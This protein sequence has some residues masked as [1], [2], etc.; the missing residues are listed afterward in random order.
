MASY[1]LKYKF[2]WGGL[3][4]WHNYA[5]HMSYLGYSGNVYYRNVAGHG[6][7][8][9]KDKG[10]VIQSVGLQF[11]VRCTTE[12]EFLNFYAPNARS[13]KVELYQNGTITY[14][15]Y[16]IQTLHS[17][18]YKSPVYPVT[19]TAVTGLK[20]LENIKFT[21][22]G[23][24]TVLETLVYLLQQTGNLLGIA[25][26]ST[27][28]ETSGT[29]VD[30]YNA[31]IDTTVYSGDNCL[32]VLEKLL[33][34]F[35]CKLQQLN[36]R[37][38]IYH[39]KDLHTTAPKLFAYTG[40]YTGTG[41]T[42][43]LHSLVSY[44]NATASANHAWVNGLLTLSLN[45]GAKGFDYT[46]DAAFRENLVKNGDF[47]SFD[48]FNL[49]NHWQ[50]NAE[51]DTIKL[52]REDV[53]FFGFRGQQ[54][55]P[56]DFNDAFYQHITSLEANAGQYFHLS[57]FTA[58][59]RYAT[60]SGPEVRTYVKFQGISGTMY[61]QADG[62]W[63]ASIDYF[64]TLPTDQGT[65]NNIT[66]DS[67]EKTEIN[68]IVLPEDGTLTLYFGRVIGAW[69][70]NYASGYTFYKDVVCSITDTDGVPYNNVT[71]VIDDE[72]TDLF[73]GDLLTRDFQFADIPAVPANQ[74]VMFAGALILP[75]GDVSSQWG[76][77]GVNLML[78]VANRSLHQ[79]WFSRFLLDGAVR[80]KHI[81]TLFAFKHS[82][83]LGRGYLFQNGTIDLVRETVSGQFAETSWQN[84]M[85]ANTAAIFCLQ[86]ANYLHNTLGSWATFNAD[87]GLI[88]FPTL[89]PDIFDKSNTT[90]WDASIQ[91]DLHYNAA[92]PREW[93]ITEFNDALHTYATEATTYQFIWGEYLGINSSI[94]PLLVYSTAL[95]DVQRSIINRALKLREF[96]FQQSSVIEQDDALIYQADPAEPANWRDTIEMRD[97]DVIVQGMDF[98][99]QD[100]ANVVNNNP[101]HLDDGFKRHELTVPDVINLASDSIDL[102]N[103]EITL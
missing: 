91:T 78:E 70:G 8:L 101:P 30:F 34:N 15:G 4:G 102:E 61:L 51:F 46:F 62:T 5:I 41:N 85:F 33:A 67:F 37:W 10:D 74:A 100:G 87:T 66:A 68:D 16:L 65:V 42:Q 60:V 25:I 59:A 81:N 63:D 31:Y 94:L 29:D 56:S 99:Q 32:E 75:N 93:Y 55:Y 73:N 84:D 89:S 17:E 47:S 83:K 28:K 40:T 21:H 45:E 35:G 103:D 57:F 76:S 44:S 53:V 12:Y 71:Y 22:L 39:E 26:V 27:L 92:D 86:S 54:V 69:G 6:V 96:I 52:T 18:P 19:L 7:Q 88:N 49:P 90:W 50:F 2:E 98:V 58:W 14:T 3:K 13:V 82:Y 11:G 77:N 36:N 43:T 9:T 80:S 48:K 72:S 1:G 24:Y 23:F 38:F 64:V 97:E 20:Q 95:T 79:N